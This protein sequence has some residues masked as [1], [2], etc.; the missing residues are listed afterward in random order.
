MRAR[1]RVLLI[2]DPPA[3]GS[4]NF[5]RHSRRRSSNAY[6]E[7]AQA[8]W[9]VAALLSEPIRNAAKALRSQVRYDVRSLLLA[10]SVKCSEAEVE[11][12]IANTLGAVSSAALKSVGNALT[13]FVG[14]ELGLGT[15]SPPEVSA[16]PGGSVASVRIQLHPQRLKLP[17]LMDR[18]ELA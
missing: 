18:E 12:T 17:Q 10:Y 14:T 6:G 8:C 5:R 3:T 13:N 15:V 4:A 16:V 9:T 1:V 2:A 11:V 7:D